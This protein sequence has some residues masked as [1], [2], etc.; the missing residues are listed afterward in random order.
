MLGWFQALMPKEERFF[1]LFSAHA[2]TLVKGAEALRELL[3]GGAGVAD[4]C[5]RIIR[6][7]HEADLVTRETL[8]AVRR[9]FITPFDRVDIQGLAT[10]LD[11]AI[12]QMQKTAKT[13]TLYEVRDF[14]PKMREMGDLILQSSRRT[15]E[16]VGLL[17]ALRQNAARLNAFAEEITQLEE[18]ADAVHD[19][20]LKVLFQRCGKAD[21]MGFIIGRDIYSHLEKVMD[22]FEDVANHVSG[23]VIE[24]L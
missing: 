18:R 8:L 13:I 24:Q 3:D 15:V 17:R 9:T 16:G 22:R 11:D 23:I 21:A 14:E 5:A 2:E 6:H 7:E 1:D 4:C 12:D 19:D 20:G 10:S